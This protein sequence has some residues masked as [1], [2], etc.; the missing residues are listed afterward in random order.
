MDLKTCCLWLSSI[1]VGHRT[2]RNMQQYFGDVT[3][4]LTAPDDA[5]TYCGIKS[6]KTK[7]KLLNPNWTEFEAYQQEM[8]AFDIRFL[9]FDEVDYPEA[10]RHIPDPPL[11]LYYKGN[12]RAVNQNAIGMVGARK[13]TPV[14]K[15][16]A[17][18]MGNELADAGICVVSGMAYGIDT[19]AHRGAVDAGGITIG[20][21]GCGLDQEYPRNNQK[22]KKQVLELGGALISEFPV[23]MVPHA[24]N[25]PQRNRIISGLSR[26][27]IVVEAGLNSG[28]LITVDFA[29]EQNRDVFSVPGSVLSSVSEGTNQLIKEGAVPVTEAKDILKYYGLELADEGFNGI[30][31]KHL[32]EAE[33]KVAWWIYENQPVLTD[34]V[35]LGTR[36]PV[37]E[38]LP[39][40]TILE[41]KG[42]LSKIGNQF[43]IKK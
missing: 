1:G 29:L 37:E 12:I 16:V 10:L 38:L 36:M 41:I 42:V 43:V 23:G 25:F 40:L 39:I 27:V 31:F 17:R 2:M 6:K 4:V 9:L 18:Q 19:E 35:Q 26:G 7:A 33:Q 13:A 34:A 3:K 28:S 24:G 14:G 11:V 32:S 15:H 30:D 20:V 8:Q 22:L 5:V 21:L